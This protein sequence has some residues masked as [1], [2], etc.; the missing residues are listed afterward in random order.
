MRCRRGSEVKGNKSRGGAMASSFGKVCRFAVH[1]RTGGLRFRISPPWDPFS[2][3]R[4]FG[5][6]VF[7]IHV[8]GVFS[9]RVFVWTAPE[10][11]PPPLK[12]GNPTQNSLFIHQPH[13]RPRRPLFTILPN[14]SHQSNSKTCRG[15]VDLSF[16]CEFDRWP[17]LTYCTFNAG[18]VKC[19]LWK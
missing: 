1:M 19:S 18:D 16:E 17:I 15:L 2:K 8:D 9:K 7:R 5:G 10:S 3:K 6:C 11:Q 14:I 4:V 13:I 12:I